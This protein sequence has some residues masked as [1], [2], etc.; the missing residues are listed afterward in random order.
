MNK[1]KKI[2]LIS[3]IVVVVLILVA[4]AVAVV[5]F[6]LKNDESDTNSLD[7]RIA[8]LID[9]AYKYYY[10]MYGDVNTGDGYIVED[11]ETYYVVEDDGV[12]S[13]AAMANLIE[14]I[15]LTSYQE[16]R[17]NAEGSNEY[18]N[19]GGVIY[20]K[21]GENVCSQIVEFDF[22][23]LNYVYDENEI[24]LNYDYTGTYIYNED[25]V[26]RLGVNIYYCA[27]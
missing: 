5:F 2:I 18:I 25:G 12:L 27:G 6:V 16:N 1:K 24:L 23:N 13:P 10:Y 11:G 15:F 3:C 19:T 20:V 4:V 8:E 22:S 17:F 7:N 9:G 26:W 21:K 14:D